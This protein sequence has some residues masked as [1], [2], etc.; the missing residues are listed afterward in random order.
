MRLRDRRSQRRP[1]ANRERLS[2]YAFS[3]FAPV[4]YAGERATWALF[5]QLS[6]RCQLRRHAACEAQAKRLGNPAVLCIFYRLESEAGQ[7]DA[8]QMDFNYSPEDEAFRAEFRAWLEKNREYATPLREPL[9]D[10]S[11]DQWEARLRWHRKL[12][13]GGWIGVN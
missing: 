2:R 7:G 9:A 6:G 5:P 8:I 10:E 1:P 13:E 3:H 12:N 4:W 11:D